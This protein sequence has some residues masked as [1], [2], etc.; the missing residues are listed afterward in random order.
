MFLERFF[1]GP[2]LHKNIKVKPGLAK[3]QLKILVKF[4]ILQLYFV[5]QFLFSMTFVSYGI[6]PSLLQ[7]KSPYCLT[8]EAQ[9]CKSSKVSVALLSHL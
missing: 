1:W 4:F 6:D 7:L 8:K 5:I 3:P 2:N 9:V